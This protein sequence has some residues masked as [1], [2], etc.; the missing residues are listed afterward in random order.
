MSE[1]RKRSSDGLLGG[2]IVRIVLFNSSTITRRRDQIEV[3][4]PHLKV[5]VASLASFLREQDFDVSII[6]PQVEGLNLEKTVKKIL[7]FNPDIVGF[8]PYTVEIMDASM[9]AA[10][11]KNKRESVRTVVGGPHASAL[12]VET[13]K[14]FKSFDMAVVGEGELTLKE[15][16]EGKEPEEIKGLVYRKKDGSIEL[17]PPRPPLKP[18]DRLPYPAWDLYDLKKYGSDV[19]LPVEPLRGCPYSCIFCYRTLGRKVRYKSPSRIVD[20]IEYMMNN[21]GISSFRFLAGTFPLSKKHAMKVFEEII[22]RRLKI[23]WSAS[24]RVDT[25]DQELLEM[26]KESG[27]EELQIGVESGDPEILSLCGKGIKPEDA[28]RVFKLCKK[29]GIK[30]GAN[31]ILGLPGETQ[32]TIQRTKLL[33]FKLLR[34]ASGINFAILVPYPGTDVYKM[35]AKGEGGLKIKSKD[36]RNYGKQAGL[37]LEHKNFKNGELAKI[38]SKLYLATSLR[39][40]Y[41]NPSYLIKHFSW[42]RLIQLLRRFVR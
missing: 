39:Y 7:S 34:Y 40:I 5:G 16:A 28:E 31:F 21:F 10:S 29:V 35:A 26:M 11:I 6:D 9:I 41:S 38:Q 25:L 1:R 20:E 18:L 3:V 37:A 33:A 13:L 42:Q 27:C 14:E 12:P 2:D 36:W 15:I 23:K 30:A 8:S 32:E 17:N 22:R 24:T 19:S 4:E